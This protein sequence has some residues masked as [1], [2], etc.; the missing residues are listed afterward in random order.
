M[1][2]GEVRQKRARLRPQLLPTTHTPCF[3]R[4]VNNG[5][6]T[7]PTDLK[8]RKTRISKYGQEGKVFT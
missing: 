2:T 7:T 6:T 8:N 5:I 1:S 3:L 4:D